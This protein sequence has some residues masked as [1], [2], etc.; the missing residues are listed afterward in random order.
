MGLQYRSV[1][2]QAAGNACRSPLTVAVISRPPEMHAARLRIDL[3]AGDK[4]QVFLKFNG[5]FTSPGIS[6]LFNDD[7]ALIWIDVHLFSL[8]D[9]P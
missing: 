9:S 7:R 8:S 2:L 5:S 3:S 4:S 6:F 1:G